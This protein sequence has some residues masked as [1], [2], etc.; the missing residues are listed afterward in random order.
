MVNEEAINRAS[1]TGAGK[2]QHWLFWSTRDSVE[3]DIPSVSAIIETL[4]AIPL[5]WWLAGKTGF[6]LPLLISIAVAPFVLL[7]SAE[8]VEL[9][10]RWFLK[11]HERK[12]TNS[13]GRQFGEDADMPTIILLVC[14]IIAFVSGGL[15]VA[16]IQ[17]GFNDLALKEP[18]PMRILAVIWAADFTYSFVVAI[19]VAFASLFISGL[20]VHWPTWRGTVLSA[21]YILVQG[22]VVGLAIA[23]AFGAGID[24]RFTG[25]IIGL[26]AGCLILP[27]RYAFIRAD[28]WGLRKELTFVFSTPLVLLD[29]AGVFS[30]ALFLWAETAII[31]IVATATHL[32]KG[33]E[34]LPRNFRRLVISTSPAQMP[35]LIPGLLPGQTPR[36]LFTLPDTLTTIATLTRART[37]WVILTVIQTMVIFLPAWLYRI[38]LKSTSWFWWPLT[39]L[40]GDVRHHKD[41]ELYY[42]LALNSLWSKVGKLLSFATIAAF[43]F[44]NLIA[45]GAIFQANPLLNTLGYI[46]LIDWSVPPWQLLSLL[47]AGLTL[48]I[49][50]R[51]DYVI[52][53]YRY[54]K[55]HRQEEL[56]AKT[57]RKFFFIELAARLR[58]LSVSAFWIIWGCHTFLYL[59]SLDCWVKEIPT[60]IAQPARAL[61]GSRLPPLACTRPNASNRDEQGVVGWRG[62]SS[63]L[64]PALRTVL[65]FKGSHP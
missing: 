12:G 1:G 19:L 36:L 17:L 22:G 29:V 28:Q 33:L 53:Q 20:S 42:D 7:R 55:D 5:F 43:L 61:Y 3:H 63:E 57:K 47:S 62:P 4:L 14:L 30:N 35:E 60:A 44:S 41:P 11:W 8:S 16:I 64:Q 15:M 54:A 31:R 45:N 2:R 39:L 9:G 46:F 26:L 25:I 23:V 38:S 58:L 59:N 50:F 51:L 32:P 52:I 21:I 37:P 13:I 10:L 40:G 48:F 56:L 18:T 49:I 27:V 24:G 6:Y 34:A 65:S